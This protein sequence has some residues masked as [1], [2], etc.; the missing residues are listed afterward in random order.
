MASDRAASFDARVR[1]TARFH[2]GGVTNVAGMSAAASTPS[3]IPFC[4][5][6]GKSACRA[7]AGPCI[8]ALDEG[9]IRMA[10][11][12][13]RCEQSRIDRAAAGW[14]ILQHRHIVDLDQRAGLVEDCDGALNA[15][16]YSENHS[17]SSAAPSSVAGPPS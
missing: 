8:D 17:A 9:M 6:E 11:E 16:V 15:D 7:F 12:D 5:A 10:F 13:D 14:A 1:P 2:A 4:P 3:T